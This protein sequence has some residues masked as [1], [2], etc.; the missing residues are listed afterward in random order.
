MHRQKYIKVMYLIPAC[1]VGNQLLYSH[2]QVCKHRLDQGSCSCS[3]Q[4]HHANLKL[5][6]PHGRTIVRPPQGSL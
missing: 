6:S 3:T 4:V 1:V 5:H 2:I